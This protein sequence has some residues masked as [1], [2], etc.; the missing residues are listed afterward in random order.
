MN[1]GRDPSGEFDRAM[2]L[3]ATAITKDPE[4]SEVYSFRGNTRS[5]IAEM[6]HSTGRNPVE[7]Y[8]EA[9]KDF[10]RA[11]ELDPLNYHA[12]S[13]RGGIKLKL[14]E[15]GESKGV[16]PE[17][18]LREAV[19]D[20]DAALE[21]DP[22]GRKALQEKAEVLI[23]LGEWEIGRGRDPRT[24]FEEA[25]ATAKKELAVN[26]ESG[27]SHRILGRAYR[28]IADTRRREDPIP[29]YRKSIAESTR[30]I[31]LD[32]Q[33]R[34]DATEAIRLNARSPQVWLTRGRIGSNL[35]MTL[36]M[37]GE[38]GLEI[39]KEAVADFTESLKRK[40]NSF[41]AYNAR[42]Y[43]R[44][45]LASI[46]ASKG[47]DI[48]GECEKA[49]ADF[50]SALK[51]NPAFLHAHIN[52]ANLSVLAGRNKAER[53]GDPQAWYERAIEDCRA[54]LS[55]NPNFAQAHYTLGGVLRDYGKLLL[56]KNKDPR[57][58]YRNSLIHISNAIRGRGVATGYLESL[59]RTY[60][61][62][63]RA[64]AALGGDDVP[65]LEKALVAF[66]EN[67]KVNPA[68]VS[69][70]REY[71]ETL[72]DLGRFAEA[73]DQ[74][75]RISR[76]EGGKVE[77]TEKARS[78]CRKMASAPAWRKA[79]AAA[80]NTADR[81]NY[82]AARKAYED[83]LAAALEAEAHEKEANRP[84]LSTA[85]VNLASLYA[86]ASV[87]RTASRLL[88]ASIPEDLAPDLKKKALSALRRAVELGFADAALLREH[89]SFEPLA[90]LPEF[91]KLLAE[92]EGK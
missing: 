87:G 37:A 83:G 55:K 12:L 9:L 60:V 79:L 71:A 80:E 78:W 32:L 3:L 91:G 92:L 56:G 14:S 64:E 27:N 8:R 26:P 2:E 48:E 69:T 42:G 38:D 22:S 36:H 34:A 47:M 50:G 15:E 77:D 41:L 19:G 43:T 84:V 89:E 11:V 65:P 30:A 39:M 88:P 29:L 44:K 18:L 59:G 17:P 72:E 20:F 57:R 16:D 81:G 49:H 33:Y 75:D 70:L 45:D 35:G 23:R 62:L 74:F 90:E 5:Y 52:R 76:I 68:R 51:F 46:M 31:E 54:A 73:A 53:G 1:Q 4:G 63:G 6:L 28:R 86:H 85:S 40:P 58:H 61:A 10:D 21:I 66:R 25:I 13:G 82:R 67:L 24:R 7:A